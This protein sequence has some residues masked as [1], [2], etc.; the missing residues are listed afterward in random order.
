MREEASPL[1]MVAVGEQGEGQVS[2]RC[3]FLRME[4]LAGFVDGSETVW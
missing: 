4:V 1:K 2:C 3:F